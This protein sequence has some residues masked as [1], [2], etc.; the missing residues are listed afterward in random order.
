MLDSSHPEVSASH[1]RCELYYSTAAEEPGLVRLCHLASSGRCVAGQPLRCDNVPPLPSPPPS[2]PPHFVVAASFTSPLDV[3]SLDA[4]ALTSA[5][6]EVLAARLP[7]Y[8][9]GVPTEEHSVPWAKATA[10]RAT[11]RPVEDPAA[12]A[13]LARV[14]AVDDELY[15]FARQQ[16]EAAKEVCWF[17]DL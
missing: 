11:R 5:I 14:C 10:Q 17:P 13:V 7:T 6:R 12:L 16:L 2:L 15:E 8:F 1:Q 3:A 4:D 9:E